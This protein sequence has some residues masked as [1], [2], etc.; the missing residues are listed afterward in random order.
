MNWV[1]NLDCKLRTKHVAHIILT[2]K[3]HN[4]NTYFQKSRLLEDKM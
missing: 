4:V 2:K 3:T 1:T